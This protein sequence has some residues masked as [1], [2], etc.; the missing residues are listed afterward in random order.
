MTLNFS[1]D[2]SKVY[3][4]TNYILMV[5]LVCRSS[6]N[7]F[8][9]SSGQKNA[10]SSSFDVLSKPFGQSFI[11]IH[12]GTQKTQDYA[13]VNLHELSSRTTCDSQTSLITQS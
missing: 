8:S 12:K 3:N 4:R 11:Y 6:D 7:Y 2:D 5:V 13:I 1:F 9:E 10:S